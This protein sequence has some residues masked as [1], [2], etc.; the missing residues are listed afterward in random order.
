MLHPQKVALEI[1]EAW[2]DDS[3]RWVANNACC[4]FCLMWYLHLEY[5]DYLA[6]K[7][8]QDMYKAGA[9][10]RDCVVQWKKAC[11]FLVKKEPDSIEFGKLN[12]LTDIDGTAIVKFEYNNKCHWVG[13]HNGHIVFNPLVYSQCVQL[14]KPTEYRRLGFQA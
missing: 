10:D 3:L 12:Q 8:V 2:N 13:V 1:A 14:G 11:L 7:K 5:S 6:I 9:V 4:A